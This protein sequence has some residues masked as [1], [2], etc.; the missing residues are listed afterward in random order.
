MIVKDKDNIS[1][2]SANE[3]KGA[4]AEKQMA[5]YLNRQFGES[6]DVFVFND[7]R[8][9]RNGEV[10]QIDHLIVHLY[11]LV[12]IE[13]KSV[14]GSITVNEH[15]EFERKTTGI[16]S[17]IEQARRQ[18][19]LLR[20]LLEDHKSE[21]RGKIFGLKQSGF[22]NC[23]INIFVAIS[24]T[25]KIRRL[26]RKTKIP[27]LMKADQVSGTVQQVIESHRKGGSIQYGELLLAS[28]DALEGKKTKKKKQTNENLGNY[29]FKDTE[30][31]KVVHFLKQ[32]HRPVS[33]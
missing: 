30:L 18:G 1:E 19:A 20:L 24:D 23:P 4:V 25:G 21:L 29:K 16:P 6:K 28:I 14:N 3:A 27:E 13:S 9:E 15:L 26:G 8:V 17:P 22:K 2:P 5:F 12:I 33:K 31:E 10:A 32:S 11:G 7:L